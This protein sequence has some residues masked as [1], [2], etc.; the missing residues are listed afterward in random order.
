M[1]NTLSINS[2]LKEVFEFVRDPEIDVQVHPVTI[3]R[4]EDE[5]ARMMIIIQG[6]PNTSSV[7]MANLMT[8]VNDMYDQAAQHEASEEAGPKLVGTD[9]QELTDDV[10]LVVP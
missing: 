4:P 6:K 7:I 1:S 5:H 2:S 10:D 9:G 8:A 3:S